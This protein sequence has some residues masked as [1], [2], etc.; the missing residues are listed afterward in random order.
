MNN[1]ELQE[2]EIICPKCN[3]SGADKDGQYIC[4]KCSGTGKVDWISKAINKPNIA[5]RSALDNI[6]VKRLLHQVKKN[7]EECVEEFSFEPLDHNTIKTI[8]SVFESQLNDIKQKRGLYDYK[9]V[10]DES[11]CHNIDI[12]IKPINIPETCTIHCKIP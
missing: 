8:V 6:N 9:V 5:P 7:V 3:G 4:R 12:H 1:I 10:Y 11:N 2:H